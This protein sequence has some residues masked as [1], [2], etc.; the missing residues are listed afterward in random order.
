MKKLNLWPLFFI[1]IFSFV[2]GMII[3]TIVKSSEAKITEDYSFLKKYQEVDTSYDD[4]I[5]SNKK[6]LEKYSFSLKIN[7]KTLPLTL[8]DI[9]YSQ[10]VLE[11]ISTH[12][13]LFRVGNNDFILNVI[14]IKN[15][16][17]QNIT[18]NLKIEKSTNEADNIMLNNSNFSNENGNFKSIVNI[19]DINNW[20]ITGTIKVNDDTGYI[21]IKTNAI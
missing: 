13:D 15:R 9:K 16:Q 12:K 11:K 5:N 7:D 18:V 21:F 6:F 8:E 19:K 17:N 20:H 14:D 3:W 1:G 4:I 10:R 2:F